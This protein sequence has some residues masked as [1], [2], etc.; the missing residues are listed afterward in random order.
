[1]GK[2][3]FLHATSANNFGKAKYEAC[4]NIFY[5]ERSYIREYIQ[6]LIKQLLSLLQDLDTPG[7]GNE[8]KESKNYSEQ[9]GCYT[10]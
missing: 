6:I 3:S 2:N 10:P 1:V 8:S 4:F 7:R 5:S 9:Y